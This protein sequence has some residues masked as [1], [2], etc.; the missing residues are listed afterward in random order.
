MADPVI[1]ALA[2]C[3]EECRTATNGHGRRWAIDRCTKALVA[4]GTP[5]SIAANSAQ[6]MARL[7]QQL[8]TT[9]AA[10]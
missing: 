7:A 9:P 3:G 1:T 2:R 4:S 6:A 5:P 8:A 10:R